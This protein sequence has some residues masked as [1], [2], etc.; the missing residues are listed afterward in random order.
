MSF[1]P[2]LIPF[3]IR[4]PVSDSFYKLLVIGFSL[5]FIIPGIVIFAESYNPS[6]ACPTIQKGDSL[7]VQTWKNSCV[8]NL[9]NINVVFPTICIGLGL[10]IGIIGL[11]RFHSNDISQRSLT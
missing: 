5:M 8:M 3:F 7:G 2:M 9:F 4:E 11:I 1:M 10:T 6:F